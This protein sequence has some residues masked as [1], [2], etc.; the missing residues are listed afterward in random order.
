MSQ[1][2]PL[3]FRLMAMSQFQILTLLCQTAASTISSD[4]SQFLTQ[5]IVTNQA[6]SPQVFEAQ[7]IALVEQMQATTSANLKYIDQLVSQVILNSQIMSAL[8]TNS[9]LIANPVVSGYYIQHGQYFVGDYTASDALYVNNTACS[10]K[11]KSNCTFQAGFYN[12]SIR[13]ASNE[14]S[15]YQPSPP[16]MFIVPGM[17]VGCLPHDSMLQST[18]ECFYNRS[19]LDLIGISQAIIP[20]NASVPS[21]FGVNT[22]V[23]TMFEQLF[24]ETWQ[25]SSNFTNY[26]NA[27]HPEACSYTYTQRGNFLYT[28]T[29]LFSLIGGLTTILGILV[30]LLVQFF[31]R[32]LLKCQ[33]EATPTIENDPEVPNIGER[34]LNLVHRIR[35][36]ISTFNMFETSFSTVNL[37][38][39]TTRLYIFLTLMGAFILFGYSILSVTTVSVTI[40]QPSLDTFEKLYSRYSSTLVCP[41]TGL[42]VTYDEIMTVTP[43]FHQLCSSDFVQDDRWLLYFGNTPSVNRTNN[44]AIV[45][46][47]DGDFRGAAGTSLFLLM[48]TL[49]ETANTTVVNAAI[50]FGAT[51]LVNAYLMSHVLFENKTNELARQFQQETQASFLILFSQVS[52]AI[53]NNQF[54]NPSNPAADIVKGSTAGS[55]VYTIRLRLK[56]IYPSGP[57]CSC[58][59]SSKCTRPLGFYCS[60]SSCHSLNSQPNITVPGM[61]VGCTSIDS[62]FLSTLTC[63][64]NQSCIQFLLN[65]YLFDL[66]GRIAP[67]DPRAANTTALDP[68][69]PSQ[70][71]PNST[72]QPLVLNMFIENWTSSSDYSTYY[73]TCNPDSCTYTYDQ[74]YALIAAIT[75]LIAFGI[76]IF[77]TSFSLQTRTITVLSPSQTTFSYLQD[78]HKSGLSCLCS[79]TSIQQ[80][81]FLSVSPRLHQVCSSDF[82]AEQWWGFLWG[83]DSVSNFRDLQLLSIQFRVLASLCS[84]AQQSIDSDTNAFLNNKL[85]TVEAISFSSFQAQIDSLT[86]AFIAQTPDKFRRTQ[87]F[88]YETFRANQLLVVPPTDWQ[89]AFTTAAYNYVIATV[90]RNSFGNNYSCITSL[91]SF[92]RPLYIDANYKT[93]TLPGVVASCLP[94]DG[95]RLSTLECFF[96]SNCILNLTSIASTRNTTIWI[97]KLLN[98]STPSIYPS[99]TSIGSLADSLFVEDWGVKSNYSSYFASCAPHSCSY[100]YINHNTISYIITTVLG[101]YGGLTVILRFIVWRGWHMHRKIMGWMQIA[102]HPASTQV[103]P[104]QP[105]I[106]IG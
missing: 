100:Q 64:Y 104:F 53:R 6:L 75:V 4:L 25:N 41:C 57:V 76:I 23:N 14:I 103:V 50:V 18:L 52:T 99:N 35:Q 8:N 36:L 24:V 62:L 82:V 59:I 93:A 13:P 16:P 27:C 38:I 98:A 30:P 80:N 7:V 87:L 83:T 68:D 94:V 3:D 47:S 17:L 102:P 40:Q 28:M 10:C 55:S 2:S 37:G 22:T 54:Y 71:L 29:M 90:P 101:L 106:H 15:L 63:L 56:S 66:N 32:L 89:L 73:T 11:H 70:F 5:Q 85:V 69:L 19:C 43:Q 96:N 42:S 74:R 58:A 79:E 91:D 33:G 61:F 46:F 86:N 88:I 77:F 21:R 34:L 26:Y 67:I 9:Y 60:A 39:Q 48:Q 72:F 49:C 45:T 105:T 81:V 97:P 84:L 95:I 20:L 92:S 12:Y 1:F 51:K 31:R 78:Q 44:S 65:W